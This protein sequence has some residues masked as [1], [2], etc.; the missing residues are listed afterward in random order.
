MTFIDLNIQ[1]PWKSMKNLIE[2]YYFWKTT[3]RYVQRKR[4]KAAENESKLKQVFVP[5]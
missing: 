1:L 5:N 2:Y 4:V 3:D